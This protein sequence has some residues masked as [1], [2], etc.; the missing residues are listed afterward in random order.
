MTSDHYRFEQVAPHAWAAVALDAGA[1]VGN[2]G[3]ADVGGRAVV[4]DCGFTPGAARDLRA[5]A[6]ELAG[7]VELLFVTHADFDH[8]GGA[9]AFADVPILAAETTATTIAEAGPG[10]VAGMQEQMET[11]L[12]ELEQQDAPEWEREQGRR[13]VAEIPRLV[14]TPPTETFTGEHDLGGATAIECGAAHTASDSVVWLPGERVLFAGD[15]VGVGSHLNLT[16]G[17]PPETWL[18]I[19]DRLAALEP[20]HVVPGHGPPSGPEA[21]TAVRRYIE[22]IVELAAQPGDHELPPEYAD[23]VFAE[24][25]GQNIDALR[26]R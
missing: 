26:A 14:L 19:L 24:G 7:P 11:Y 8:Y 17:H 6:E 25:F 21:L 2:A 12:A 1:G 23:W 16:R 18:A 20:D 9:H 13:I 22:T 10:R 3:I 15:L 5:A 4:V